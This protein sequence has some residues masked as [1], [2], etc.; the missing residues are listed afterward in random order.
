MA[1]RTRHS[2]PLLI[3]AL[4]LAGCATRGPVPAASPDNPPAPTT[5]T[6]PNPT[7]NPTPTPHP[8]ISC[9]AGTHLRAGECLINPST[10]S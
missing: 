5:S 4:L 3:P 1:I 9:P 7:P 2:L 8:S 6:S 10:T